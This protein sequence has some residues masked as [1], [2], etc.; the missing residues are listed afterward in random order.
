VNQIW[1]ALIKELAKGTPW[2]FSA[3]ADVAYGTVDG[4]PPRIDIN[5]LFEE[6]LS[7][8]ETIRRIRQAYR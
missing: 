6:G 3:L 7:V 8:A 2:A 1:R 5:A 4:S